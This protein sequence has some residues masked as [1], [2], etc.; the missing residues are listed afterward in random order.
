MAARPI[1]G[2]M[3]FGGRTPREEALRILD[4]AVERGL[5]EI[6]TANVYGEGETERILGVGLQGRR[7]RFRLVSKVGIGSFKGPAEGLRAARIEAGVTGILERLGTD[8]LEGLYLHAPD[9]KTPLEETL[10][11]ISQEI[12]RGRIGFFGISNYGAWRA[13]ELVQCCDRLS[14]PRPKSAQMLYNLS[15]RDLEHEWFSFA[16][17]Y[18]LETHIYNPLA[19]GLLTGRFS[20]ETPPGPGSRIGDSARYQKRYGTPRMFALSEE[21]SALA[22]AHG[23]TPVRLAYGWAAA[24]PEVDAI[25][26]G[27]ATVEQL[28]QALDALEQPLDPGLLRAVGQLSAAFRGSDGSYAR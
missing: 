26:L 27:P 21:L 28:D 3:N 22:A 20:R 19:G 6:D 13:L 5:T 1:L 12:A 25:V 23:T 17:T 4:R 7:Q 10:Q 14:I 2:T 16:R 11:A 15:L 24:R 9:F 18:S 8:R